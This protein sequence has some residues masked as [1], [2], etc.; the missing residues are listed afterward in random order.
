M[1]RFIRFIT[2]HTLD[3]TSGPSGKQLHGESSSFRNEE[4]AIH[5]LVIFLIF[6]VGQPVCIIQLNT[7]MSKLYLSVDKNQNAFFPLYFDKRKRCLNLIT[8]FLQKSLHFYCE[9]LPRWITINCS[10]LLICWKP[11][12]GIFSMTKLRLKQ[13]ANI[14]YHYG[15]HIS[16]THPFYHD[17]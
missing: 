6:N 8:N 13:I 11:S 14:T 12:K 7:K 1:E 16:F 3:F 9:I 2:Q 4:M 17:Q 10:P 15:H 5:F